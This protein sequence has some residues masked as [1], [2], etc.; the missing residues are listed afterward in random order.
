[1][2]ATYKNT[3]FR[4]YS[5]I[6]PNQ[7]ISLNRLLSKQVSHYHSDYW[8]DIMLLDNKNLLLDMTSSSRGICG[9]YYKTNRR[10]NRVHDTDLI[11]MQ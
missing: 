5:F 10:E 9:S 11:N 2:L 1:M 6:R 3:Y 7:H 8:W 4:R